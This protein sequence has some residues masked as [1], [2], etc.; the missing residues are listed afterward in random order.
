MRAFRALGG[1]SPRPGFKSRPGHYFSF[2]VD[3]RVSPFYG[4]K[5]YREDS[6]R[7]FCRVQ[8][9]ATM[10]REKI[11]EALREPSTVT[12][13][14]KKLGR[15]SEHI[16]R[17]LREL[18]REGLVRSKTIGRMKIYWVEQAVGGVEELERRIKELEEELER[19][20]EENRKLREEAA[21]PG[22]MDRLWEKLEEWKEYAFKLA[23][24][25]AYQ[26]GMTVK[27]VLK[28]TGAPLEEE[29]E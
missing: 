12:E 26:R 27:E 25:I 29:E 13:L 24:I 21:R 19:L 2:H 15:S 16:K 22:E 1:D 3:M 9:V 20:R 7:G 5:Y 14:V 11:L 4:I 10:I 18:E 17:V 28:E 8:G 23:D 6:I